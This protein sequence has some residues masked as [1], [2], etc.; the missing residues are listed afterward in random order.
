LTIEVVSVNYQD[1]KHAE[2]LVYLLNAYAQDPMGGGEPLSESTQQNLP[3]AL[4]QTPGAFSF[5]IYVDGKPAALINNL[6]GFSTFKCKPLV[7]IHDVT[8][9]AEFR[10]LGLSQKLLAS[11]EQRA[12]ELGCCKVTM[13]VLS[14]NEVAKKAYKKYGFKGYELDPEAGHALFWEKS[15][16]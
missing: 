15:V 10:G 2:D 12:K 11:V 3:Q 6:M 7:N 13:E 16:E 8:V 1:S 14:G 5:I 4:A 9:L